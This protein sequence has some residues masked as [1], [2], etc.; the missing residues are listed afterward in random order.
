MLSYSTY[1][2]GSD[3]GIEDSPESG[4]AI[5]VD[6]SGSAY[7]TGLTGA[8]DFPTS[9]GFEDVS[10]DSQNGTAFVTKINATGTALVYSTYLGGSGQEQGNGIAVDAAGNAYVTGTTE[11]FDF[12]TVNPFQ[13]SIDIAVSA[14]VTKLNAA[15]SALVYSTYLS[16]NTGSYGNGIAVDSGGSAYVT[17]VAT[18]SGFPTLNAYQADAS[19]GGAFVTKFAPS[20]AVLTYSTYLHGSVG[21]SANGIAVDSA[22]DAY[23]TGYTFSPDFPTVNAF[24]STISVPANTYTAFV[25]KFNAAGS[26]LIYSTFLGGTTNSSSGAAIAV[27]PAGSAYVA[28]VTQA[29]DFPTTPNAFQS[30]SD[31]VGVAHQAAFVTKFDPSGATLTYSSYLGTGGSGGAAATGIAV[32]AL[33]EAFVTGS[34]SGASFPSVNS[35]QPTDPGS[36]NA[37]LTQFNA[38]GSALLFSTYLGGS[39]DQGATGVALD[40]SG[41][42]Y[43]TGYTSSTDFPILNALQATNRETAPNDTP[44][45]AFVAKFATAAAATPPTVTISASPASITLGANSTIIWSSTNATSCTASG[46]WSGTEATS[47]SLAVTPSALGNSSYTLTCS[48]AGGTSGPSTAV[49]TVNPVVSVTITG[50]AGGGSLGLGS[51]LGL[52]LLLAAR[53]RRLLSP[54][55]IAASALLLASLHAAAQ[56]VQ[57]DWD[58][59]FVGV[60][61]GDA[62]YTESAGRLDADL[63]SAGELGTRTEV[64]QRKFGGVLYA[65]VP[66]YQSLSLEVGFADLGT[67]PVR[68]TTTSPN[69]PQLAQTTANKLSSAGRGFTAGLAAPIDLGSWFAIEPRL[70]LLAYQST[71][72]VYTSDGTFSQDRKGLGA[73]A[74]IAA[75]LRPTQWLSLGAGVDCFEIGGRCS[76]MLYSV[77]L[78]YRF[79]R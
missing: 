6:S 21:E 40:A 32:N 61:A 5:A 41:N 46:A 9:S 71:Q 12:P 75:L 50:K 62:D 47:G 7:V 54:K 74:G 23:V 52:A 11:S 76:V 49:L 26:A 33:G 44:G 64:S 3:S 59:A 39:Q 51:I 55:L 20:G 30:T 60:R 19:Q 17:G 24:Q 68:I 69:I 58:H 29:T 10:R 13:D 37:F 36:T 4:Y 28:G 15:G 31:G 1:L 45:T 2:G 67:F 77:E 63:L 79:G 42:A 8:T 53:L 66:F 78:E 18:G 16:G 35:V 14:F 72:K 43:L 48:G 27:D 34:A 70:G 22:G 38:S 56:Q 25:T 73:D 65:G 57:L